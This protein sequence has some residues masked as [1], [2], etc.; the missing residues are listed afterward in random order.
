MSVNKVILIGNVGGTPEY[1]ELDSGSAIAKFSLA[2]SES[3]TNKSGEKITSTEWH[4]IEVWE[5]LA[6]VV[7]KYVNKGSQIYVE[8]KIRTDKWTDKEGVER[9]GVTIRANSLTLIGGTGNPKTPNEGITNQQP[10]AEKKPAYQKPDPKANQFP[11]AEDDL[12]DLPF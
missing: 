7:E 11:L 8:G 5:G 12:D 1:K 6:R 9:T 4:R 10:P 3:Y 2:T